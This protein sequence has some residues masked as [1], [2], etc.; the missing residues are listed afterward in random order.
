MQISSF[1]IIFLYTK[2]G[3]P[4]LPLQELPASFSNIYCKKLALGTNVL[5]KIKAAS[6][7][8]QTHQNLYSNFD[9]LNSTVAHFNLVRLSF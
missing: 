6:G 4:F 3:I 7:Y 8:F 2:S 1:V 9:L 5:S